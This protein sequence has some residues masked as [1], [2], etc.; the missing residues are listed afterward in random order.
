MKLNKETRKYVWMLNW[1]ENFKDNEVHHLDVASFNYSWSHGYTRMFSEAIRNKPK[2]Y[3]VPIHRASD[4]YWKI[5]DDGKQFINK[6]LNS[7]LE[8]FLTNE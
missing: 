8:E 4:V 1:W 7:H 5:T 3:L 2:R 6:Y